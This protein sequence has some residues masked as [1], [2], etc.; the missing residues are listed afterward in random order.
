[1]SRS[2]RLIRR[3]V[4]RRDRLR[5]SPARRVCFSLISRLAMQVLAYIPV[6]AP[7]MSSRVRWLSGAHEVGQ[8]YVRHAREMDERLAPGMGSTAVQRHLASYTQVRG[9]C[10]GNYAEASRDVHAL[11]A[12][13]AHARAAQCRTVGAR[14]RAEAHAAALQFYRRRLGVI[15]ARAFARHR[16]RRIPFVGLP[17]H[18]VIRQRDLARRAQH[19]GVS[20]RLTLGAGLDF[21]PEVLY[22]FQQHRMPVPLR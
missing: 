7:A 15:F 19:E 20:R 22:H 21:S 16:L 17:R 6:P 13:A 12:V 4:H 9:L 2:R 1:M 8:E 10:V 3:A 5:S 11:I 18:V 14:S